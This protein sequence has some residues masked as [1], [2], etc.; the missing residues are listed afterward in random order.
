MGGIEVSITSFS[1]DK[2]PIRQ[3]G[4]VLKHFLGTLLH[5]EP[6]L[7]APGEGRDGAVLPFAA[8][9]SGYCGKSLCMASWHFSPHTSAMVGL[10]EPIATRLFISMQL[11]GSSKLTQDGRSCVLEAGSFCLI[12]PARDYLMQSTDIHVRTLY[13]DR[14]AIEAAIPSYRDLTARTITFRSGPGAILAAMV[15]ETFRLTAMLDDRI[16]DS[17][18]DA[19]PLVLASAVAADTPADD[20]RGVRAMHMQRIRRYALQNLADA[21]L[22][23]A[24][25][26]AGVKLSIRYMHELFEGQELSLMKWVWSER[27]A[28]ARRQLTDQARATRQIGEIAYECGFSDVAHFSRVFR[29]E[30]GMTPSESR[31]GARRR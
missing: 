9:M 22:D 29:R 21:R 13:V 5:S 8:Q 12:D 16:A 6:V 17:I 31:Q 11:D 25:I 24:A 30:F 3:R 20:A 15:D 1:T 4:A 19:I 2:F 18:A 28:R 7:V 27:L 23:A 10:R 14:R 26:G